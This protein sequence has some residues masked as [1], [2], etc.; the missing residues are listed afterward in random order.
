MP[1]KLSCQAST[2]NESFLAAGRV[3]LQTMRPSP[4]M[5][6]GAVTQVQTVACRNAAIADNPYCR[7]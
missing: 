2:P 6:A 5:A 3:R 4:A 7:L 1:A